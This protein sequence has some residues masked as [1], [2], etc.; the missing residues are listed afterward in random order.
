MVSPLCTFCD[1]N[2]SAGAEAIAGPAAAKAATATTRAAII[3]R[4]RVNGRMS[5]RLM[6]NISSADGAL[7]GNALHG[8]RLASIYGKFVA[9]RTAASHGREVFDVRLAVLDVGLA[10]LPVKV[11]RRRVRIDRTLFD[12]VER[13]EAACTRIE[14]VRRT[15]A[16]RPVSVVADADEIERIGESIGGV[17]RQIAGIGGP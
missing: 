5:N 6:N 12:L 1:T 16:D 14:D 15:A 11:S 13:I 8:N 4:R 2:C 9:A 7:H 17:T 3:P 10:I